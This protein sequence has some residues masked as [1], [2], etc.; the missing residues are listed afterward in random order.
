MHWVH[1]LNDEP[2]LAH[3]RQ[4]FL[5]AVQQGL[6][7]TCATG[8][9]NDLCNMFSFGATGGPTGDTWGLW[10]PTRGTWGYWGIYSGLGVLGNLLGALGGTGESTRGTWGLQGEVLLG[11]NVLESDFCFFS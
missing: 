10:G 6:K 5:C 4:Q 8:T 11:A 2:E 3:T 7:T 9:Q 1:V